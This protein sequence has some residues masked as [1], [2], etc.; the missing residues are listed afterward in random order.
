MAIT[1]GISAFYPSVD[2]GISGFDILFPPAWSTAGKAV[3]T[4]STTG[5]SV[6]SNPTAYV[7]HV[8]YNGSYSVQQPDSGTTNQ[9]T[10]NKKTGPN[11]ACTVTIQ[12]VQTITVVAPVGSALTYATGSITENPAGTGSSISCQTTNIQNEVNT[13]GISVSVVL[14]GGGGM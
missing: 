2:G 1:K 14:S 9:F 11:L 10:V 12:V 6:S 3:L 7:L 5:T 13:A 4:I 8:W